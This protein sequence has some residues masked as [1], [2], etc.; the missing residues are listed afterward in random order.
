MQT[1]YAEPMR[2]LIKKVV[3][4]FYEPHHVVI[5]DIL[6]EN[7][8][9]SDVD[10]CLKMKMLSREFNKLIIKLKDDRI[11]KS[12]I[13]LEVKEN[14]KQNLKNV[15]FFNFAEVRDIIKFKIFKMTKEL[16][17]K[18]IS[19]DEIFYCDFCSKG[20]SALDAQ[21]CM[22][23]YV[24]KCIYCNHELKEKVMQIDNTKIDLKY[25][26]TELDD[27]IQLLKETEVLEIPSLDYFQV[28]Q[29]KKSMEEKIDDEKINTEVEVIK[30][31]PKVSMD[32]VKDDLED[33]EIVKNNVE[34]NSTSEGVFV[35]VAG[36]EKLISELTEEDKEMMSEDEYAK[37]FELYSKIN[38]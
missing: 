4:S 21:A 28:L 12:E 31:I 38:N 36:V 27:I 6:L 25:M 13:K 35:S 29:M 9:L 20:F 23:N 37:Y 5:N 26:L 24:F 17:I 33:F 10:F 34:N 2:R 7:I 15:Y 18:K 8:L 30:K 3:R 14:N 11:V 22:E 1:S 16:E 32:I 19:I